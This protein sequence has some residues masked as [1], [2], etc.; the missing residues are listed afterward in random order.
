DKQLSDTRIT[1]VGA[2]AAGIAATKLLL[3]YGSPNILLVDSKGIISKDRS[4]INDFKR[5]LA[6]ITNRENETGSLEDAIKGS[7][8][9]IGVSKG[10]LLTAEMVKSM[11]KDPII[12]A[13][14]N[15]TPEIM[16]EEA[17]KA[18]AAVVATGRSD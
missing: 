7:D 15:P 3:A 12:F 2:G 13:M 4:D 17:H 1:V 9:F 16:P 8:V 6:D 11:N 18:G 14:A 5:S 10:G